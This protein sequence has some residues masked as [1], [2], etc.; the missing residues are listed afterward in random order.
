MSENF[1]LQ[2]LRQLCRIWPYRAAVQIGIRRKPTC[3]DNGCD[4]KTSNP[5]S[6]GFTRFLHPDVKWAEY[7]IPHIENS[8]FGTNMIPSN[9][10]TRTTPTLYTPN[11]NTQQPTKEHHT[12]SWHDCQNK[13]ISD[14]IKGWEHTHRRWNG[15]QK[16]FIQ[17]VNLHDNEANKKSR[18]AISKRARTLK[19]NTRACRRLCNLAWSTDGCVAVST[20][21]Q[22]E[23]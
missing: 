16:Q 17:Q 14:L 4:A 10:L 20:W 6:Y 7:L 12:P 13:N 5:P 3:I 22:Y 9:L 21:V 19:T 15:N 18:D 11:A 8:T 1:C 2:G 23:S